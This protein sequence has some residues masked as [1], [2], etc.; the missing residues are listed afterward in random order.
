MIYIKYCPDKV[1][2]NDM[3]EH[4]MIKHLDNIINRL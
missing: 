3:K 2:K 1:T 4:I